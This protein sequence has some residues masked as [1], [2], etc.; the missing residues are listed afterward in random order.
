VLGK[1]LKRNAYNNEVVNN[2]KI[3]AHKS[4]NFLKN[5]FHSEKQ[6]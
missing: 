2:D 1:T 3:N 4:S 5:R 6:C